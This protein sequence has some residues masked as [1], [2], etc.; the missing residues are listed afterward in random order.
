MRRRRRG[1]GARRHGDRSPRSRRGR[2][3]YRGQATVTRRLLFTL[4]V[5]VA[6]LAPARA[7]A[8]QRLAP[9]GNVQG[10][11]CTTVDVPLDYTGLTPGTVSLRVEVLPPD[12]P[13]RGT[14][15]LLAGG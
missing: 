8:A 12:V 2:R 5:V 14:M 11:E 3:C 1:A 13:K 9:C 6:A 7:S 4:A 10:L 15:F